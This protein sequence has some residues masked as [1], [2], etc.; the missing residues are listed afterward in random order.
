M[1]F[2]YSNKGFTLIEALVYTTISSLLL[3]IVTSLGFNLLNN[4][5]RIL[6]QEEILENINIVL[7]KT[8]FYIQ[9]CEAINEPVV[10]GN[11]LILEMTDTDINPT[12]FYLEGA[13][14]FI[15][16]GVAGG[17]ALTTNQVQIQDLVFKKITNFN[18]GISIKISFTASALE[19]A[20]SF[21]FETAVTLRR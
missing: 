18:D 11:E 16:Q 20:V 12:R 15:A 10:S 1:K 2:C 5:Q 8:S 3:L 6:A 13:T 17:V 4:K 14:L 19:G 9:N 7:D 21:P